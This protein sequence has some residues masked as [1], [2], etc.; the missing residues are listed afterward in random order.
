MRWE[1]DLLEDACVGRR[2]SDQRLPTDQTTTPL[3]IQL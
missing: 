3:E 1:T 2:L